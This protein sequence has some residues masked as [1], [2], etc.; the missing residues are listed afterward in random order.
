MERLVDIANIMDYHAQ[1]K[2]AH[3]VQLGE[4][5]SD[6]LDVLGLASTWVLLEEGGKVSKRRNHVHIL[7]VEVEIVQ[8]RVGLIQVRLVD[9]VPIGLESTESEFDIICEGGALCERVVS[10]VDDNVGVVVLERVQ[11]GERLGKHSWRFLAQNLLGLS[12]DNEVSLAPESLRLA[13]HE[14]S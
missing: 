13:H 10:L 8:F 6:P 11:L 14:R 4:L 1:H 7:R 2:R 12:R 3:V 5:L 9:K